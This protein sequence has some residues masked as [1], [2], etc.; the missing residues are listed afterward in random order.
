MSK[1]T[2]ARAGV[3][4]AKPGAFVAPPSG[5]SGKIKPATA[6]FLALGAEEAW[7]FLGGGLRAKI[8]LP[9]VLRRAQYLERCAKR[10]PQPIEETV[11]E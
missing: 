2:A 3:P 4:R 8:L 11:D 9:L 7:K 1:L 6:L 10:M 5:R